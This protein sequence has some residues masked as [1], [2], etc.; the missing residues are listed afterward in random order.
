MK[1]WD[2]RTTLRS[3]PFILSRLALMVDAYN[4]P[5]MSRLAVFYNA[6]P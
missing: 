2:V 6:R 1:L 4:E 3:K 5:G